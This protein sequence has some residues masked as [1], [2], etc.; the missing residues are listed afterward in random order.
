MEETNK[1]IMPDIDSILNNG[2]EYTDI[3]IKV[4]NF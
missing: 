1:L 4:L 3:D 2:K